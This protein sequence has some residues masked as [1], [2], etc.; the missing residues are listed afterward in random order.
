MKALVDEK[1]QKLQLGV[2]YSDGNETIINIVRVYMLKATV[3]LTTEKK[4]KNNKNPAVCPTW[5]I[6][7]ALFSVAQPLLLEV[8]QHFPSTEDAQSLPA[9]RGVSVLS[10]HTRLLLAACRIFP[11]ERCPASHPPKESFNS[12]RFMISFSHREKKKVGMKQGWERRL[13][14]LANHY[15]GR[16]LQAT[17]TGDYVN[18]FI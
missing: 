11:A 8:R 1:G 2:E 5:D 12:L 15:L 7:S 14:I 17:K 9:I 18:I 16:I 3:T 4:K 6:L 13:K 10:T